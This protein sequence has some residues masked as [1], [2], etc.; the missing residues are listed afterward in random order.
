MKIFGKV[1]VF[2]ETKLSSALKLSESD[3]IMIN[4]MITDALDTYDADKTGK[5]DYAL[6]SS[7]SVLHLFFNF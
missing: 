1:Q 6:E 7:G 2:Q 4:K 3:F 5:V